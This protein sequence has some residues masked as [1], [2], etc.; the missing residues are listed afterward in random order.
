MQP[1]WDALRQSP[2]YGSEI[3]TKAM[4]PAWDALRTGLFPGPT[5]VR[6][7]LRPH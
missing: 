1:A 6:N 5:S 3:D 7:P 2:C 4:Q